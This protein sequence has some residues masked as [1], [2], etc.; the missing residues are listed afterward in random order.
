MVFNCHAGG[1]GGGITARRGSIKS[2]SVMLEKEAAAVIFYTGNGDYCTC[3]PRGLNGILVGSGAE[4]IVSFSS[5]GITITK[6]GD[7]FLYFVALG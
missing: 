1:S 6:T 7:L 2:G 5:D 3:V 4:N